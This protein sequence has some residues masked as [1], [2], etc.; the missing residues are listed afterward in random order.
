M[1]QFVTNS[2]A[3]LGCIFP[4]KKN[5]NNCQLFFWIRL[6]FKARTFLLHL[7]ANYF[8]TLLSS[9]L[10][11]MHFSLF[12]FWFW[13]PVILSF[14]C[15]TECYISKVNV[16]QWPHNKGAK[17]INFHAENGLDFYKRSHLYQGQSS[18]RSSESK[19]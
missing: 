5:N 19:K 4:F 10:R 17:K 1:G 8:N 11:V 9:G 18:T 15:E 12:F 6:R 16:F 13:C 3:G 2:Q 7:S 14:G